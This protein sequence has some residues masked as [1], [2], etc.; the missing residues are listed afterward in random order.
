M[1]LLG[2]PDS[3]TIS[4]CQTESETSKALDGVTV[5]DLTRILAGPWATQN[6]ADLGAQVIKVERPGA[7]DDTRAWGPPFI[8]D[9]DGKETLDSSYYLCANRGKKSVT[10]DIATAKGQEIIRSLAGKA[11]VFVENYKLGDLARYGL[12][13]ED[14]RKI[15]PRLIYCSITGFGQDGPYAHLPGYDYIFQGLGGLMSTTGHA[16]GEPGG[17]PVRTGIAVCDAL[18]GMYATSGILAALH[19][20]T[21]TG[22]GQYLDISL[23]DCVVSLTSYLAM[24]YFIAGKTPERLG[25][26]HPNMMPYEVFPCRDGHLILAVGNEAQY[27]KFCIAIGRP[28]LYEN[29]DFA[30]MG[31]RLEN[32]SRLLPILREILATKDRSEWLSLLREVGV[33]CGPINTIP[34]VFEDAHVVHRGLKIE[35][36]HATGQTVPTLRSPLNLSDSPVDY[37]VPAPMLG[38]HTEEVLREYCALTDDEISGLRK[39]QVV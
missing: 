38:Q 17:G 15:N 29:P 9:A 19:Q 23:L 35:M 28:D 13:Y 3:H 25:N 16:D 8:K 32:K 12:A 34:D 2:Y 18:T 22:R 1:P 11:D 36:P 10:V 24:N 14:L 7:G 37:V 27:R 20:R 6:L 21:A 33:P 39:E 5:L 31:K 26:G 30:T 4:N